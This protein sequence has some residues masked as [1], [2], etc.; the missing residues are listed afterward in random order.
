MNKVF[1]NVVMVFDELVRAMWS[2]F[3]ILLWAVVPAFALYMLVQAIVLL[4]EK[5]PS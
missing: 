4:L 5:V 3:Q 1:K 2:A